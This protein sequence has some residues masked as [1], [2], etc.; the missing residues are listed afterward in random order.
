MSRRVDLLYL[1]DSVLQSCLKPGRKGCGPDGAAGQAFPRVIAAALPRLV[2]ALAGDRDGAAKAEKARAGPRGVLPGILHEW[3]AVP[4]P[5]G[6]Q[7]SQV[8]TVCAHAE[9]QAHGG[10]AHWL[11]GPGN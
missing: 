9:A 4:M 8:P 10:S 7:R 6:C 1:V 11:T 3:S 5:G 2:A